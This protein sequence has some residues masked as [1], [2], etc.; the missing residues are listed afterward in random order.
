[1]HFPFARRRAALALLALAGAAACKDVSPTLTGDQSFPGGSRPVT[2][3]AFI[4]ASRYLTTLATYTGFESPHTYPQLIVANQYKGSLN[5]HA[6]QRYEVPKT[7]SYSQNGSSTDDSLYTILSANVVAVVDTLGSNLATPTTLQLYPVTQAFDWLSASWTMAVD[8]AGNQTAWTQPGGTRGTLYAQSPYT[9]HAAGDS[10][11]LAIDT[12]RIPKTRPDTLP[13]LLQT[14]QAGTR[15]QLAS[16]VLRLK[17]KPS[18]ATRDTT[19]SVDVHPLQST[20]VFTPPPP[21]AAGNWQAGG[22]YADR[23]LF[24]VNFDQ[25]LPGCAPAQQPC[26]TVSIRDVQLNR[27]AI[28]LRPRAVPLGY[29]PL[30]P[31]PLEVWIVK[32]PE[33]GR[34]APLV[35]GRETNGPILDS[36]RVRH[37]PGDTLVELPITNQTAL[38]VSQDSLTGTFA[39]LGEATTTGTSQTSRTFGLVRY[40]PEPRLRIVYTLP[41]R[42]RLP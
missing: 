3:E 1:M 31:V 25:Q 8:T 10:V 23:T 38:Q 18:N 41:V 30:E 16:T 27:V 19:I 37:L 24:T 29:D 35:P 2:L 11:Y 39:L 12:A 34:R 14:A 28:Q 7:V 32:E 20:F 26:P 42:P 40:D 36:L 5:A 33:L 13:V 21:G 22:V 6:L 15:L 17:V 9:P 4:P